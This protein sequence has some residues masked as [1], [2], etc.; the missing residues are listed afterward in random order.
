[1]N[2]SSKAAMLT[3]L[4]TDN[5]DYDIDEE[6]ME[7]LRDKKNIDMGKIKNQKWKYGWKEDELL[8]LEMLSLHVANLDLKLA[9]K[10]DGLSA[11]KWTG[12]FAK[13]WQILKTEY[14]WSSRPGS[15]RETLKKGE[16][17]MTN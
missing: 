14:N 3:A 2:R 1:M 7:L 16:W 17:V 9:G 15:Q 4:A 12:R 11:P 10:A 6:E 8:Y 13:L 5:G